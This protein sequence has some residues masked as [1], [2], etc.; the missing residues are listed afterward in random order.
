MKRAAKF[1]IAADSPYTA[2]AGVLIGAKGGNAVDIAVAASLAATVAEA[3]M[4][5]LGG[6][7]Y[8]I[9]R[10]SSGGEYLVD[11]GDQV[12]LNARS[13]FKD[14]DIVESTI[15]YGETTNLLKGY[16]TVAVPGLLKA[17]DTL[18]RNHGSLP[19]KVLV[20]PAITLAREGVRL[21]STLSK[22]I[23]LIAKPILCDDLVLRRAFL[24]PDLSPLKCSDVFRIEGMAATLELIARR[25]ADDLYTGRLAEALVNDM[26]TVGG[27]VTESDL[28]DYKAPIIEPETFEIEGVRFSTVK[29]PNLGGL[30]LRRYL[31]CLAANF[32]IG[33]T[34]IEIARLHMLCQKSVNGDVLERSLSDGRKIVSHRTPTF[35]SPN[36]THISIVMEDGSAASITMSMG[37]GSGRTVS[38]AGIPLNNSLGET[39]LNPDGFFQIKPGS[40]LP[41]NMTPLIASNNGVVSIGSPGAT[42]IPGAIAQCLFNMQ[43]LDMPLDKA[44]MSPRM[45]LYGTDSG[46][47]LSLEPGIHVGAVEQGM[48]VNPFDSL[49]MYFGAVKVAM[50]KPD[51]RMSAFADKRRE[52][53]IA[54]I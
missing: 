46:S 39:D 52:G 8:I 6:S 27:F 28:R 11:G 45:H 13:S 19:W 12:P 41:S 50:L 24:K 43:Y 44:V 29:Q 10:D 32:K 33:M 25:G 35:T 16:G 7:A 23:P 36:T 15:D 54:I 17:L 21:S 4:C 3:L 2:E 42:R 37:C 38:G 51:G 9:Y 31:E 5:S 18:W 48:S 47:Q 20:Q 22:W 30:K 49:D 1:S 53:A 26:K 14:M 40:R 34:D